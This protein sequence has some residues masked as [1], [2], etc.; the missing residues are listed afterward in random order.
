MFTIIILVCSFKS[1]CLPSFVLIGG[2]VRELH[3]HL[4]PY[5]NAWP[6]HE[7][8]YCCF[9]RS[10]IHPIVYILVS[11]ELWVS[12]TSPSFFALHLPVFI[13]ANVFPEDVY[14]C[15]TITTFLL[16]SLSYLVCSLKSMCIPS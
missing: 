14:R 8:V 9:T 11:S 7:A 6:D 4:C 2:C 3:A 5:R 13:I 1:M 16:Q 10:T 15:F 12:S